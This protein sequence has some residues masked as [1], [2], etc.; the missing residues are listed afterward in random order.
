MASTQNL[1]VAL[2]KADAA[3]DTYSAQRLAE[4]IKK[5][6]FDEGVSSRLNQQAKE[7]GAGEALA[8]S[9]GKG[10]TDIGRGTGLVDPPGDLE[11]RGFEAL[12]E[13]R[14]ITTGVGEII[15]QTVPFLPL[16]VAAGGINS[17]TGRVL[18]SGAVGATEAGV[19]ANAQEDDVGKAAG[20]GGAIAG[21]M[22]LLFPV[23]GRVF[24]KVYRGIRGREPDAGLLMK[25]GT[26]SPEMEKVMAE[27]GLT[28]EDIVS[29][30]KVEAGQDPAFMARKAIFKEAGITPT[31]GE[32]TQDLA[33]QKPEQFLLEQTSEPSGD[34]L[35][36]FMKVRNDELLSY[37]DKTIDSLGVPSE[38]GESV[39]EM[40]K[41]AKGTLKANRKRAY[42]KLAGAT[43]NL[44]EG[45]PL[46]TD[47]FMEALPDGGDIRDIAAMMPAEYKALSGLLGEFGIETNEKLVAELTGKGVDIT[48]ININN[49]ER[50]RKRLNGIEARDQTGTIGR[51]TGPIK[52]ALD[53]EVE[54]ATDQL[55]KSGNPD[56]AS[57]AKEARRSHIALK[58][59]FDPASMAEILIKPKSKKSNLPSV[60][61]SQVFTK[62][63]ARST[64][65]EQ[66][67]RVVDILAG[68]VKSTS[69]E[70]VPF[71]EGEKQALE[72]SLSNL[73]SAVVKD[74]I[75]SAF[76]A[77]SRKIDGVR[78][79]GGAA[80]Q[81]R[82]KQMSDKLDVIFSNNPDQLKKIKNLNK[83]AELMTPPSGAVPKGSAGFLME[84]LSK[85]GAFN[86]LERSPAGAVTSMA[87]KKIGTMSKNKKALKNALDTDPKVREMVKMINRDMPAIGVLLGIS[88][89]DEDKE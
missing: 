1:M 17:M 22:E 33:D 45:M 85:T 75:D 8:I 21:S 2:R 36:S 32:L 66:V 15:G 89:L 50:F 83:V 29:A 71:K 47:R 38:V 82:F 49:F 77:S 5:Q 12:K 72:Q 23:I 3:G 37:V 87:L 84:A 26:P 48:P 7:T 51:L 52:R 31:R 9:V 40:L 58:T 34:V 54:A 46:M 65:I 39:K 4:M 18:A 57:I 88:T 55:I 62:L 42:D 61:E 53:E 25:D 27:S 13:E 56:I 68:K 73:Q 63:M 20:F 86:I 6:Q 70:V 35:R 64:P 28:I 30:A 19:I 76:Q 16:G 81:K 24:N 44:T 11:R 67:Q 60:E 78:Q 14:P 79:F 59:D 69:K 10:L 74:L 80:F 43:Q 41:G